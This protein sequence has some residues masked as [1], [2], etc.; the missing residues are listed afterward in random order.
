[1]FKI[2]E[3]KN[4]SCLK[5]SLSLVKRIFLL[6][7]GYTITFLF[8]EGLVMYKYSFGSHRV[9]SLVFQSSTY[10]S[11]WKSFGRWCCTRRRKVWQMETMCFSTWISWARVWGG[12]QPDSPPTNPG[13]ITTAV[14]HSSKRLS[15]YAYF[16]QLHGLRIPFLIGVLVDY[17]DCKTTGFIKCLVHVSF[18]EPSFVNSFY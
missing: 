8:N 14:N 9:G 16:F 5:D 18:K 13:K 17:V 4:K 11:R 10:V 15:K 7:K 12:S 6:L 2:A 3:L 1:M